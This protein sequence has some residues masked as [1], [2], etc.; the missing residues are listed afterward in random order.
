MKYSYINFNQE[1]ITMYMIKMNVEELVNNSTVAH[2]DAKNDKNYQR[3]P[4]PSHYRKISKYFMY[5][6][7]PILP[8]AILGAVSPEQIKFEGNEISIEGKI[9]I[10][11]GQH[12]IEGIKCLK[13]GYT[14]DSRIKYNK[15]AQ[16]FEFPV[17]IMVV[18]ESKIMLEVDAF[19]NINSKG[20]R[21]KTDLAEALKSQKV[22]NRMKN[23]ESYQ[24]NDELI[25]ASAMNICR[26]LNQGE[27]FLWNG[28]IIQADENGKRSEQPISIIAFSKAI[29][30]IV[31]FRL[32]KLEKLDGEKRAEVEKEIAV[33]INDVWSS[34]MSIWPK[35]F[36][37][38]DDMYNSNYNICKGMGVISLYSIYYDCLSKNES[39]LE[40]IESFKRILQNAPA[41]DSDWLVGGR[42]TGFSSGQGI[43]IIKKY[44]NKEIKSLEEGK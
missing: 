43:S 7:E 3:P 11:D 31:A 41:K 12:R 20:K 6:I 38:E 24:V 14:R 10:V 16:S 40:P 18:D 27:E 23:N 4:I 9:R 33:E 28:F 35:C 39:G 44:I 37:T 2:Y 17:V 34:V 19:I 25:S 1:N 32:Y 26:L 42:F 15:L 5:E 30:Q 29:R 22:N 21:V 13:D 36:N 8:T